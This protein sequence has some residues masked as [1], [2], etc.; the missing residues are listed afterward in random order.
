[1]QDGATPESGGGRDETALWTKVGGIAAVVSVLIAVLAFFVQCR[2]SSSPNGQTPPTSSPAVAAP[3]TTAADGDPVPQ[4]HSSGTVRISGMRSG[5]AF[6]SP[7]WSVTPESTSDVV[8]DAGFGL[9][10]GAAGGVVD[11]DVGVFVLAEGCEF[12][13]YQGVAEFAQEVLVA[14]VGGFC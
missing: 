2:P 5:I 9:S 12:E 10:A 7:N 3:S 1:M 14:A 13:R 11:I 8:V 6:H 4:V